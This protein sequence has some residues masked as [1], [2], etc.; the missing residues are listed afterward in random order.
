VLDIPHHQQLHLTQLRQTGHLWL[1]WPSFAE[2]TSAMLPVLQNLCDDRSIVNNLV[3]SPFITASN[4][5]K[6]TPACAHF[7]ID[8][9]TLADWDL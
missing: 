4:L 7:L 5:T 8:W 3:Q 6:Y 2:T 9:V 1:L